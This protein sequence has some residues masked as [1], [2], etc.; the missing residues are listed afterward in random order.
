MMR[1]VGEFPVRLTDPKIEII[2]SV[3]KASDYAALFVKNAF[4]GIV[5]LKYRRNIL[6][7]DIGI[8]TSNPPSFC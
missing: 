3:I 1:T 7:I 5:E 2:R 4:K 8:I 6:L